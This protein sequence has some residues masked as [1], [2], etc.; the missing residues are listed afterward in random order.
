ALEH[1]G[2]TVALA[3]HARH[4]LEV[5]TELNGAIRL[6]LTD[7]RMPQLSGVELLRRVRER[8][9]SLPCLFMTGY[10][11]DE[12]ALEALA[13]SCPVLRKP[14]TVEELELAVITAVGP[15]RG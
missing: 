4:A 5:L 12:W 1:S 10:T 8:W 6:L 13:L 15:Q 9:P 14:F 3:A 11:D 2:Y 7:V